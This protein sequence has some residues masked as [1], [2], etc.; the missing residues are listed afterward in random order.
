[1]VRTTLRVLLKPVVS[2]VILGLVLNPAF[3]HN[4]PTYIRDV[5][6]AVGKA[7]AAP[8][9]F[10][11]GG[12][13]HGKFKSMSGRTLFAP[14]VLICSKI[15]LLPILIAMLLPVFGASVIT[16]DGVEYSLVLFG[17]IYGSLPSA[18]AVFFLAWEF[19]ILLSEATTVIVVGTLSAAPMMLV[20]AQVAQ[21]AINGVA[22]YE[23]ILQETAEYTTMASLAGATWLLGCAI[24]A[25]R[26]REGQRL[27]VP[28]LCLAIMAHSIGVQT[29]VVDTNEGLV[30]TEQLCGC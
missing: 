4:P 7:F 20:S 3:S 24:V 8:A 6:S 23:T 15:L 18:T 5:L 27:N 30:R 16:V 2:M 29:C 28:V 13:M 25:G 26:A 1:M 21:M 10:N 19:G 11:I 9:L 17:F 12:N 22:Q 14:L